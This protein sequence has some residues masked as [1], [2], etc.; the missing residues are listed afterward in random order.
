MA[1]D[2]TLPKAWSQFKQLLR[3]CPHHEIPDFMELQIFYLGITPELRMSL[4]A[5]AG[6]SLMGRCASEARALIEKMAANQSSWPESNRPE[7]SRGL[8]QVPAFVSHDA[9]IDSLSIQVKELSK[10]MKQDLRNKGKQALHEAVECEERAYEDQQGPQVAECSNDEAQNP[11]E[12]IYM[13]GRNAP[14]FQQFQKGRA[15]GPAGPRRQQQFQRPQQF[16]TQQYHQGGYYPHQ[17]QYYQIP[18]FPQQAP[19]FTQPPTAAQA[20]QSLEEL[21]RNTERANQEFQR[22]TF[23]SIKMLEVQ[24]GQIAEA[25]KLKQKGTLPRTVETVPNQA[26]AIET[27]GGKRKQSPPLPDRGIDQSPS[28]IVT[29]VPVQDELKQIPS[30]EEGLSQPRGR[31]GV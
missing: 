22:N 28:S 23:A 30:K 21:W 26:K 11:A 24:V 9:R 29:N 17:Q 1:S 6:S 2:E 3:N 14:Q 4:D 16:A 27:R 13:A 25:L 18:H 8:Y 19:A 7:P 31:S 20:P 10:L 5:A 15:Q 12:V